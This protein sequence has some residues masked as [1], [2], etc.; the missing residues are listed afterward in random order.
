MYRIHN[1]LILKKEVLLQ[2]LLFISF[3]AYLELF[4]VEFLF[5]E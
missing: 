2:S 3:S 1:S 5:A 4:Y